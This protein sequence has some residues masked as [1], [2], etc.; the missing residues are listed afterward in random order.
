M[1]DDTGPSHLVAFLDARLC[2]ATPEEW[3]PMWEWVCRSELQ[4]FFE[5]CQWRAGFGKGSALSFQAIDFFMSALDRLTLPQLLAVMW[6][7]FKDLAFNANARR[8]ISP[9][10]PSSFAHLISDYESKGRTLPAWHRNPGT[11]VARFTSLL[12]DRLGGEETASTLTRQK[13]GELLS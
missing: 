2:E 4:S 10:I 13:W 5:Y 8:D 12:W 9:L 3:M 7:T 11:S 1:S 6:N